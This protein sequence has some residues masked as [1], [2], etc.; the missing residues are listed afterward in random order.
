VVGWLL[1]WWATARGPAPVLVLAGAATAITLT[2]LAGLW[3]GTARGRGV[4]RRAGSAGRMPRWAGRMGAGMLVAA[5]GAAALAS[6]GAKLL[7]RQRDPLTAAA[8]AHRSVRFVGRVQ[9]DPRRLATPAIG[10]EPQYLV[11]IGVTR[12]RAGGRTRASSADLVVIA[13]SRWSSLAAGSHVAGSARLEPPDP[14]DSA[15]ATAFPRGSPTVLDAG[16]WPWRLAEHLRLGLRRACSRLPGLPTD[17]GDLL[18]GL[19]VGD[20][21]RISPVLRD[22]LRT[23]GL[24]HLWAVSGANLAILAGVTAQALALFGAGRRTRVGVTAV[25]LAGF[26][27]LARPQP[28]V[29]RAAV[30][31]GLTLAGLLR[32]RRGAGLP[33]LA[34]T[35]IVLVVADPWLGRDYGFALSVLATGALLWLAPAWIARVRAGPRRRVVVLAVLVPLA[36]QLVTAPVTVLLNPVISL[37][38]V[39][40]NL[41]ADPAVAPATVAGVL[42]AGLS[43]FWPAGAHAVAWAGG[44]ATTW[45]VVVAHRAAAM[46][47]ATIPWPSGVLG[48]G[49]L[50]G[51]T[52]L[53]IVLSLRRRWLVLI[54]TLALVAACL[55]V[56]G[57]VSQLPG[58]RNWPPADWTVVQCAV[59]QGSSTVVR[60]GADHAMLV[61]TGPDPGL[62]D[63][64][65]RRIGVHTIDLIVIT[66][67]HEDHAGGLS[68]ALRGRGRPPIVV[69]PFPEPADQARRV[70]ALAAGIGQTPVVARSG[71]AGPA[72]AGAWGLRWWLLPP[73]AATLPPAPADGEEDAE[74]TEINNTSVA[75]FMEVH[76][77]R[78]MALG[79]VEPEAQQPLLSTIAAAHDPPMAPVDV[80]VVAHHGSARQVPKLYQVLHPRIALIGVGLHNDYGHPAASCLTMLRKIGALTLRTDTEGGLAVSGTQSRLVGSTSSRPPHPS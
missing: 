31:A 30:M 19:V 57:W 14:G 41:L 70:R 40:A 60:T 38:S 73:P 75:V 25:V 11:T 64:C 48:A 18:P 62:E 63:A 13:G 3:W 68:G 1:T 46:P 61:D 42:A 15:A 28:S 29:L 43:V 54:T 9:D 7:E 17:A 55:V 77:L 78:V 21:S 58:V 69:S 8:E 36:A 37:A 74:G 5:V 56:P 59:G 49:L 50:T 34:A 33:M 66:H 52:V 71:M 2:L 80:V 27:V 39:P 22:D 26:V 65:L 67:F 47:A 12:V 4:R 51:L 45:I 10:G 79:D 6:A 32:G 16:S 24:T 23:A 20:T 35:V 72:G 44:L 76:G 53:V